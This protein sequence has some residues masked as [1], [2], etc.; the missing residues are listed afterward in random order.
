MSIIPQF[1]SLSKGWSTFFFDEKNVSLYEYNTDPQAFNCFYKTPFESLKVIVLGT[2][3][4]QD[5]ALRT[6]LCYE[7]PFGSLLPSS[8]V[9]LYDKMEEEGYYPTR[10]GSLEY[11]AKQGVLFLNIE[12]FEG[13]T[14]FI[15]G[16]LEYILSTTL[17][18][19]TLFLCMT[20]EA[21]GL[22][23]LIGIP[24]EN[25]LDFKE[26]GVFKRINQRLVKLNRVQLT[27]T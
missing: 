19:P 15:Q 25:V 17:E 2:R 22:V 4:Y 3:P 1:F 27:I 24:M 7:V 18:A 16:I 21:I 13:C 23:K 11:L 26:K 14:L 5:K 20:P 10:D 8:L 9:D 6:G 12:L